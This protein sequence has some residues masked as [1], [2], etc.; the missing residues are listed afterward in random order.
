[1]EREGTHPTSVGF[2]VL[3]GFGMLV[4]LVDKRV[5]TKP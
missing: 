4:I 3:S 1:M 2:Q 5:K